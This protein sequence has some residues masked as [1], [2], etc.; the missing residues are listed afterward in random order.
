[1]TWLRCFW[2]NLGTEYDLC[3]NCYKQSIR[4]REHQRGLWLQ[5][6]SLYLKDLF[7]IG[8]RWG[9]SDVDGEVVRYTDDS[10]VEFRG[11]PY[12]SGDLPDPQTWVESLET[13]LDHNYQPFPLER[14][15]CWIGSS[16][17]R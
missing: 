7:P 5:M 16:S 15:K 12:P 8:S 17:V 11:L 13:L 6:Q 2:C 1:M 14:P 9:F 3:P 10:G 4:F